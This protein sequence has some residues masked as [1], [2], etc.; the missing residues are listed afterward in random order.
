MA[1]RKGGY[2]RPTYANW[3]SSSYHNH[4][5]E[6]NPPSREP[7][8]DYGIPYGSDVRA[9]EDGVILFVDNSTA[10]AE[11][12]RV[13][14]GHDDGQSTS[15]IHLSQIL[16]SKGQRVKR[17]QVIAKSGASA[18]GKE[19]GVGA[20]VHQTLFPT[21]ALIFG[22]DK[23]LDF[24]KQVGADNDSDTVRE[25]WV[26]DVQ[27]ALNRWFRAGLVVDGLLGAKTTAAILSAQTFLKKRGL[28]TG[29]LD[30]KWGPLTNTALNRYA[31][32]VEEAASGKYHKG[33]TK[34]I[35][36]LGRGNAVKGLQ[37]IARLY[38]PQSID[39]I[40]G[41][42][43]NKGFQRFLDQNYGGSL[44]AWLRAKWGYVGNDNFG[45][46]MKAALVRANAANL[47][48]L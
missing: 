10:G 5:Y 34:D 28:Y 30:G 2:L 21:H 42:N 16:V 45:P 44:A 15:P 48:A 7:G 24:E 32:T 11:G 22:T 39:G 26:A 8:T 41:A 46:N 19:W 35:A 4:R 31:S 18:W 6:R 27:N 33:T 17:G 20:H 47:R 14:V 12:R 23:T 9:A 13:Q 1:T 25:Q 40:W 29:K 3:I 37:K 38:L 43:S 36:S